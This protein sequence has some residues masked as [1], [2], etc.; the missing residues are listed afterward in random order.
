MGKT[1]GQLVFW[2]E[3]GNPIIEP[4]IIINDI[5]IISGPSCYCEPTIAAGISIGIIAAV[6][7]GRQQITSITSRSPPI[8]L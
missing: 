2:D 4:R 6:A 8:K 5:Q 7:A 3:Q 1:L